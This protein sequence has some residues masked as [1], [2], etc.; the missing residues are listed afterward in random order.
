MLIPLLGGRMMGGSLD[1][2]AHQ[3]PNSRLHLA[4]IGRLFG[5]HGFGPLSQSITGGIEGALFGAGVVGAM[6]FA[7]LRSR[8]RETGVGAR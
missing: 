6:A 8:Q 2:L 4:E 1:A 7:Q 3:F 5:E